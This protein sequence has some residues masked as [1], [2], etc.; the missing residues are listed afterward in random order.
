MPKI[1]PYEFA[2][3]Q[4]FYLLILL[5]LLVYWYYFRKSNY[6]PSFN[7]SHDV[8]AKKYTTL[9]IKLFKFLP[10]L[11]IVAF[12]FIV[13][14]LARPQSEMSNSEIN[15]EG[16]DI[17]LALDISSSMNARDFKPD[18]LEAAK[19]VAMQFIKDRPNDRIGLVVFAGESFT[20]CPITIDH[21]ILLNLF[22]D[23]KNGMVED[24][25]AIGMGLATAVARLK[26]SKSKTKI[27]ILMTD[28]V[29]NTG[30]IDPE[31]AIKIAKSFNIRVYTIGIGKNGTAPYPVV[32]QNGNTYFQNMPVEIDTKLLQRI[33][34]Q[35]GGVYFRATGNAKL[36]NIYQQ[37]DQLEKSKIKIANY[38]QKKE[39]FHVFALIALLILLTEIILRNTYLKSVVY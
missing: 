36:E 33:A 39:R 17:V 18:R 27:V 13:V 37:I 21:Q 1:F 38:H 2:H 26:E 28:G 11:R 4:Y 19:S 35:T 14:A 20:Q 12:I 34:N 8:V 29:N 31:S 25:T 22:K 15:T 10:I 24:G 7:V 30:Y 5:P 6:Y 3:P 16:I 9:K 23:I 32:D